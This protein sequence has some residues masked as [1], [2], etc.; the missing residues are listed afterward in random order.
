MKTNKYLL[1]LLFIFLLTQKGIMA[2][3]GHGE[4]ADSFL[5][6]LTSSVHFVPI[7]LAVVVSGFLIYKLVFKKR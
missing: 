1:S 5:H 3:A 2:H 4:H 7:L 6:Y